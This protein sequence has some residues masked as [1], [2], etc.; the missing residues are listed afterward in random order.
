MIGV[1]KKIQSMAVRFAECTH[2][3]KFGQKFL[4]GAE[5]KY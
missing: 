2:N 1:E 5:Y 3:T 4:V